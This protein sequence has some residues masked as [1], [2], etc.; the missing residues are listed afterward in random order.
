MQTPFENHAALERSPFYGG[1]NRAVNTR[2]H[3]LDADMRRI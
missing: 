1:G 3:A 2:L